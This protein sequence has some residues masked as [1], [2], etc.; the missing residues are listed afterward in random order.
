MEQLSRGEVARTY[1]KIRL[2]SIQCHG[3]DSAAPFLL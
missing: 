3:Y 1:L 2:H